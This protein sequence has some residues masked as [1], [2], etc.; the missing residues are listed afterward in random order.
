[1]YAPRAAVEEVGKPI[2]ELMRK[3]VNVAA[4]YAREVQH[5]TF[6]RELKR[7]RLPGTVKCT[8]I[9]VESLTPLDPLGIEP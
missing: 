6:T 8:S 4:K 3:E 5:L 9:N 1:M 2:R 7:I